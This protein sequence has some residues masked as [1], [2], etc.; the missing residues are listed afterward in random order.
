LGWIS[1]NKL[2]YRKK[3]LPVKSLSPTAFIPH[4]IFSPNRPLAKVCFHSAPC[5]VSSAGFSGK[6]RCTKVCFAKDSGWSISARGLMNYPAACGRG[7]RLKVL[8]TYA[9]SG[10]VL[11]PL[12]NKKEPRR[13]HS[14]GSFLFDIIYP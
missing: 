1:L 14:L 5:A 13:F 6:R 11:D 3:L 12:W 9:A 8:N 2:G 10:G 7:I 4:L